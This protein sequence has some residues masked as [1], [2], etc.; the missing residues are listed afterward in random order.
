M[1]IG[2]YEVVGVLGQ[3]TMGAVYEAVHQATGQAVAIKML[4]AD[5]YFDPMTEARFEREILIMEALHHPHIVSFL[6]HGTHDGQTYL[7][8]TLIRGTSLAT[9]FKTKAF[10]PQ[11]VLELLWPLCSA[12]DYAHARHI[13]HRDVKPGNILL[14]TDSTP[15]TAYLA[16]FGVSKVVGMSSLTETQTQIG[17]PNFM[18]PEQAK[19]MPLTGATDVYSLTVIAYVLLLRQFPFETKSVLETA[20]AV[21]T[22]PPRR[23]SVLRPGFPET[24]EIVLMRGLEK[25]PAKRYPSAGALYEAFYDAVEALSEQEKVMPIVG[26]N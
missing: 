8:M 11:D 9:Y 15:P 24:L 21:V 1:F 25:D 4:H 16:D 6:G 18:S 2:D 23:P 14:G 20:L 10:S 13:F 17:T 3:G 19:D 22:Q 5:Y 7:V 26:G 12:L